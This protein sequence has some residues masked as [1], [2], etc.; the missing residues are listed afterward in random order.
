MSNP[1]PDKSHYI[2]MRMIRTYPP[3]Y[4]KKMLTAYAFLKER[5]ISD[6]SSYALQEFVDR[7]SD[8]VKKKL[9]DTFEQMPVESRKR[10]KNAKNGY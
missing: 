3:S 6:V 9:L 1:R 7:M 5:S 2:K 4:V 8:D 10:P